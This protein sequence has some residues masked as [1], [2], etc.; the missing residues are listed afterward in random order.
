MFNLYLGNALSVNIFNKNETKYIKDKMPVDKFI[1]RISGKT[2]KKK[3]E[4]QKSKSKAQK[5]EDRNLSNSDYP[6]S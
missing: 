2:I 1:M 5:Q 4:E 6:S 3:K